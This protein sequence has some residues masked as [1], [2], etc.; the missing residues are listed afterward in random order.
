MPSPMV[1]NKRSR[2]RKPVIPLDAKSKDFLI[3]FFSVA[4]ATAVGIGT[5]NAFVN[6]Q[7]A[8]AV[9]IDLS[10][11]QRM[12]S[13]KF[14]KEALTQW[15]ET[16]KYKVILDELKRSA[17]A[18]ERGGTLISPHAPGEFLD[19]MEAPSLAIRNKIK[20][21]GIA[22]KELEDLILRAGPELDE[23]EKKE[24]MRLSDRVLE[25]ANDSVHLFVDLEQLGLKKILLFNILLILGLT[26]FVLALWRLILERRTQIKAM[27][28][29]RETAL[30]ATAAKSSFLA[31]MSHEIRTPL[32]AIIGISEIF[33]SPV[34]DEQSKKFTKTLQRAAESLLHL[35]DE[36]L[37]FSKIEAGEFR[38]NPKKSDIS[39]VL[40]RVKDIMNIRAATKGISL[41][42][43]F[44]GEVPSAV[45]IDSDRLKQVLINLVGNA[46]KFT[47]KGSVTL[48]IEA[49]SRSADQAVL[50][51][52]VIDTG[53]GILPE[54]LKHIF[55]DF[56]QADETISA[57]F[58]GTGL[59]LAIS[60]KIVELLGGDLVVRSQ[61]GVGSIFSFSVLCPV[62]AAF[63]EVKI[64]VEKFRPTL[65][66]G[67]C[68]QKRILLV[69]DIE[70]NR[71]IIEAYL[72]GL[73][74][75]VIQAENGQ[76]AIDL[77]LSE[78]FD[79]I[80]MDMRMAPVDGY[81]ATRRIREIEKQ[82]GR[83][84]AL[85]VGLSAFATQEAILKAKDVGCDAY[86]TKP[87][88]KAKLLDCLEVH[89]NIILNEY[90]SGQ[91]VKSAEKNLEGVFR[92]RLSI[93]LNAKSMGLT[94]LKKASD[95]RDYDKLANE[96]H[97]LAG[98]AGMYQLHYLGELGKSLELSAEKN[99]FN[100]TRICVQKIATY[101]DKAVITNGTEAMLK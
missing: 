81:E 34:S 23:T 36:I 40:D 97:K 47:E 53:I 78:H 17:L 89:L 56:I 95:Q 1:P 27:V 90:D 2:I 44:S 28:V 101:L 30:R 52:A 54:K 35:V 69:D 85:I 77:A 93:F 49:K 79:L 86:L 8:Q 26:L 80:L 20:D 10:G 58:G 91:E 83:E 87:I 21:Q 16:E 72:M 94:D 62:E 43:A 50:T 9:L 48:T 4:L 32:N 61:P 5:F 57:K 14:A 71:L 73:P 98:T 99:N 3:P 96:G 19:V 76:K 64:G 38:I 46:I 75:Q 51:F 60:K 41:R 88:T 29:A 6:N 31:N 45:M 15:G 12:L 66:R 92:R 74:V 84:R 18:L 24:L 33:Q 42:V 63:G 82:R 65:L 11:R 25:T 22:I 13:Q 100:E 68:P 59:G 7:K 70:D 39:E 67:G 37:D 55:E